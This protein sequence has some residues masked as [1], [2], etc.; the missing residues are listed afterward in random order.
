MCMCVFLGCDSN[1]DL[2]LHVMYIYIMNAKKDLV[3]LKPCI[4]KSIL[5]DKLDPGSSLLCW[6]LLVIAG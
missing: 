3:V 5:M 2:L 1:M 6:C 4:S